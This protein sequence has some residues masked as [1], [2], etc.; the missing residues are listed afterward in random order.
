M[1]WQYWP[2]IIII[3]LVSLATHMFQS[4]P[5]I[6]SYPWPPE[7]L[8]SESSIMIICSLVNILTHQQLVETLTSR[9]WSDIDV[10]LRP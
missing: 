4:A 5:L 3:I 9:H 1:C 10:V 6:S 8:F 7:L 2:L